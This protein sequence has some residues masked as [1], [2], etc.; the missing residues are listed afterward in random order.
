MKTK[1]YIQISILF[2]FILSFSSCLESGLDEL[3]TYS[4]ANITA[5][6]FEYRWAVAE[7]ANDTWA[8]EKLQVKTLSTS[9]TYGDGTIECT[10]KV[11]A[12]S[13]TFTEAVRGQVAL[14]NLNAYVTISPGS[15]IKPIGNSPVLGELGDFTQSDI[16][17]EVISADK[18]TKKVWKIVIK[19][20]E[21]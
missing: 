9:A 6:N 12:A 4:E 17:Y 21:K 14:S 2:A 18:K 11:P 19:S 10:L 7:N 16:S 8:G 13:G 20:F 15:T 3:E 1:F 5:I